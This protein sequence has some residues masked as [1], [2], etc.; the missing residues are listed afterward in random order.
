MSD[1]ENSVLTPADLIRIQ[2]AAAVA[3]GQLKQAEEIVKD[4]PNLSRAEKN[5][6][7]G[8]VLIAIA[9]NQQTRILS[10]QK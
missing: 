8:P 1:L 4:V 5:V 7:L 10:Q 3:A 9:T 6:L 2:K